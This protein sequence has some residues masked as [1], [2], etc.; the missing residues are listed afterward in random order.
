[1]S[2]WSRCL[3]AGLLAPGN[4]GTRVGSVGT[5]IQTL[6]PCLTMQWCVLVS[7]VHVESCKEGESCGGARVGRGCLPLPSQIFIGSECLERN[8]FWVTVAGCGGGV[9]YVG[10]RTVISLCLHITE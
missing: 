8:N 2:N 4:D 5:A 10:H 1:M 6:T 7:E 9:Q 3:P